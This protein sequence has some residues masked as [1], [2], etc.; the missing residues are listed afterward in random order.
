M[1]LDV[2]IH[3]SREALGRHRPRK[4]ITANDNPIDAARLHIAQHGL[5]RRQI[6]VD[7][8]ES[9]DAHA[10]HDTPRLSIGRC[11]GGDAALTNGG[12]LMLSRSKSL[13][14]DTFLHLQ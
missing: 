2:E 5:E 9:G 13:T 8:V 6:A 10:A 14:K 1:H 12:M 4:H 7:V 11:S 3:Q